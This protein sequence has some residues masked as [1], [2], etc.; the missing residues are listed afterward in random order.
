MKMTVRIF[1]LLLAALSV[2]A[3]VIP[4]S[5][6]DVTEILCTPDRT[7]VEP[8]ES[9]TVTVS[10]E[11]TAA[12]RA[13]GF[14]PAFDPAVFRLTGGEILMPDA[15]LTDVDKEQKLL[16]AAWERDIPHGALLRFTLQVLPDAAEGAHPVGGR[17]SLVKNGTA[18]PVNVTET[19]LFVG[20]GG[21]NSHRT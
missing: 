11:G 2:A 16:C 18:V 13:C 20:T 14:L 10:S 6:A 4:A 17:A 7:E 21:G 19:V 9:I 15:A 8:G 1:A 5:A 3:A 12:F